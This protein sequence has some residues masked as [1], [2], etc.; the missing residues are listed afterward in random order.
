MAANSRVKVDKV[1]ASRDG[2]EFHEAWTARKATQLLWPDS[3]LTAIAVEGLSP[4]DQARASAQTVEIA[5]ITLYFGDGYTFEQ[6]V[7]TTFAQFKY[8]ITNKDRDFRATNAKKTVEKFG[9]TYREYKRKYT[10]QAVQDKLDFQLITNQPISKTLLKAI[11]ALACNATRKGDVAK[12][13]KQFQIAS[14]LSGKPLA[15]FAQKFKLIGRSGSLP[16]TKDELASLLVDWSATSDPIAAARLGKLTALVREKAGYAGTGRNLITRTDT[17]AALQI[18]DPMDLLPCEPALADVGKVLERKQ[19]ADAMNLISTM[20]GPLL[21]HATGGVGKT[22]FMDT[23]ATMTTSD[24]EVVFFACFGGGAYRSPEDARHLPKRGLIHIANTL[25]FRGLCDPMLPGS[26]D[27]QT[28]L[29]TFRRRLMQC[30]DTLSRMAPGRKLALFIDAIDNAALAARQ[31]SEDCFPIKLLESLDA[32][33]IAGVKLIVS[34]RT[35]PDRKPKTCA[36]YNEFKLDPFSKDETALFLRARLANVSRVEINVAQA[37]S[38]GNPRILEYLIKAGRGLL[39]ESEIDKTIE[40]DD[41]IQKRITDAL[42]TAM[43]RG[44]EEE[45]VNAFLA[46]L[47]VLPPP[48]PMDEYAGAHGMALSAIESFASDLHPLLERTNQG[49]MFRDE[50]TETLVHKRYASSL[51]A[52]RRV[53]SNLLARQDVSVYAARALPGLLHELDDGVKL[54]SLAFDDRIPSSITSAVGKRNVRYARLKAATLHAAL[55]KDYDSLVRFLL[56][57]STIAAVDQRGADYILNHPDLV[58]AAKD[59]DATRRLFETRTGWPGTRHARLAI[60][61]TLSGEFEEAYRHAHVGS[62]WIEHHRRTRSDNRPRE[63]GPERADIAAI[64]FLLISQ[65]RGWDAAEYL[66]GWRDWYAYE[67]C[68]LV[69]VY[70]RL[71]Q[72]IR[73]EPPHRLGRFVGAISEIGVLSAALS[74]QELSRAK[75]RDLTVKLAKRCKRTTKLYLPDVYNPERVSQLQEGLRK[76]ATIALSLGLHSEAM[77]ISLRAP[78]QR[79]GLWSFRDVFYNRDVFPFLFRVALRAAAKCEPIHERDV[80]PRELVPICSRIGRD[81]TGKE[82]C[83][84][85]KSRIPKYVRKETRDKEKAGR[86]NGLSYED[87]QRAE[88]FLN[89]RLEPLLAIAKALSAVL[90]AHPRSLNKAFHELIKTW[91]ESSRDRDSYRS[92]ETGQFFRMLGLDI[93]IFALGSRSDL[94]PAAIKHF[95]TVM[96]SQCVGADRLIRIVVIL[97]QRKPLQALAGEQAIKAR[98]LI[99]KED[100]VNYRASLFGALGRAMLPASIDEASVY[101]RAGLEQMDAIGSGDYE[102][103]NE[104]LLFASQLKGDERDERDFHTLTNVCELNMGEEPEKFFWGAFG[105]GLAQVAGLRGLAKLSRWDDRSKVALRNTLLPYLTGLLESGKIDAKDALALNRPATPVEY[106]YAGTR[107]FA[108]ALRQQVGPDPAVIAELIN[109]FRDDNPDM[110]MDDTVETLGSLAR[111]ALG[112]SSEITKCLSAARQGYARVRDT[113]NERNNYSGGIDS[114]VRK[115]ADKRKRENREAL[116]RI[117]AATDPTD[118]GSL[119]KAIDAFNDLGNM[120]DLKGGLFAALRKRIPYNK[121]AQYIRQVAALQNLLYYWKLAELQ[122]ARREWKESSVA[123]A[124][125]YKSLAYPIINAHA[126][127]LI[128]YGH[129]SGSTIKDISELT[130]VAISDLVLELIKIFA[131]PD[132]AVA[133]SVWLAFATFVCTEANEGQGQLALKRLISSEA[134]RLADNV[135]DGTWV[136]GRYPEA[137][138]REIA[139]GLIWRVLGSPYAMDRWHAAHCIRSF[140]KFG[141]WQVIDRLVGKIGDVDAGPFQAG[142]LPF[143]Y[144]HARLWLLIALARGAQEYPAEISCYKKELLS[145]ALE[146]SEPHV[147]MR[148]FAACTLLTCINAGHLELPAKQITVL[149]SIDQSP[150]PRL[151]EKIR[152]NGGFYSGRPDSVPEPP[153]GFHLDYDFHKLDV[154]HLAEVFGQPCWKVADLMSG[155]VHAIDPN[156]T[157]MYASSGRESR[158]SRDSYGLTNRYHT[159]GQH[160][161]WHA[162]FLA[163]GRLL[164]AYPVTDDWWYEEDPW[165][166]WFS[167]YGLTRNDGLWLSDGTDRTPLDTVEFL[168][169][170][171]KKHM[172]ITGDSDTILKLAGIRSRVGKEVIVQGLWFSA[173][174]VKIHISSALVPSSKAPMLARKLTREKPMLVWVPCFEEAEDPSEYLRSDVKEYMPW[175]VCPSGET[176]LDEHDPYGVSCANFRPRLAREFATFC[177]LSKDDPLGRVWKDKRGRSVVRAQAWVRENNYREEGPHTGNRLFCASLALRKILAEFDKDLLILIKLE[178]YEKESHQRESTWTHKVAVVRITRTLDLDYFKGRINYLHKTRY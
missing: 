35:D 126:N 174:N 173:D 131:R 150:H 34:C 128:S 21:I 106:H 163:A 38:G 49:L 98:T 118:E 92:G 168:F 101:F 116:K 55:K 37:R 47:A 109:Q 165:G 144:M 120:Y 140:A 74:F 133:G 52:L 8:S 72:S 153:F 14:G 27:V 65:G 40:L 31:G 164:K 100:D 99:E 20:S 28:L 87:S 42:A 18:G 63:Q 23:L 10:A 171:K 86:S 105:R 142:E 154:D 108:D 146:D 94:K 102:F 48:V 45:E 149:N 51:D 69:F 41:L 59:V 22:V 151:K 54:F 57:L 169:E 11:D 152:K 66:K 24:H 71:A 91:E 1:R 161:G 84:K 64:P 122:E 148:H 147:L 167:R 145:F 5:D 155:I 13:A 29:N 130:G 32:K 114:G 26:P 17:L 90:G 19:L 139:A 137:N 143:F 172:A 81:V 25:A 103:T 44:Y 132:S 2:H 36:M 61:N 175:I 135:V 78:Y 62:E 115:Q 117:A 39:E 73:S 124:D 9:K 53:A 113:H 96:H 80:L 33:P 160:L 58:V 43:E 82:F 158:F 156:V 127:D 4:T 85:A 70:S 176:R 119:V 16:E 141:R 129:L 178:R 12:Q 30:I 134:A 166:E 60:A 93:A 83:D 104:I 95:L 46:G 6:A 125:V 76:A 159:H 56:E 112:P 3:E 88:N 123:L 177:S 79:P 75:R 111:E 136:E 170:R 68:E 107:E 7:R 15:A 138:F 97:A 157:S 121:R 89:Y 162:L 77:A 67:V 50:P 110:A